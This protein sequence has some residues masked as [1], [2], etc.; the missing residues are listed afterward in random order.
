MEASRILPRTETAGPAA[1]KRPLLR[2]EDELL[3]AADPRSGAA[4]FADACLRMVRCDGSTFRERLPEA[5]RAALLAAEPGVK[6]AALAQGDLLF[7]VLDAEG[8]LLHHS[9][10]QS[11]AAVLAL[12]GEAR[13]VPL[14]GRC[15]TLPA[16][17]GR[18]LY[19]RTL[20]HIMSEL[21]AAGHRRVAI[22]CDRDNAASIGGIRHAGFSLVAHLRTL[23]IGE[24]W[25]VQWRRPGGLRLIAL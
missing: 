25:A 16:A 12:L 3:F 23:V 11:R 9:F 14:I 7:A 13:T 1:R 22:Y 20:R 6:T 15:A 4:P 21:A 18:R 17:R 24:R 10:V 5:A 2:Y 19:P 8:G